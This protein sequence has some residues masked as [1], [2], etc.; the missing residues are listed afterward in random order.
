MLVHDRIQLRPPALDDIDLLYSWATDITIQLYAGWSRPLSL[1]AFREKHIRR[2]TQPGEDLILFGV[3][4]E[5]RLV[6][7]VP[8]ALIDHVERRAV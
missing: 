1:P 2:I 7:H 8:L 4:Y 3:E 6:G 5:Q